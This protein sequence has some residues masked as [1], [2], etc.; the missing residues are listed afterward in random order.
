MVDRLGSRAQVALRAPSALEPNRSVH[1]F[2]SVTYVPSLICYLCSRLHKACGGPGTDKRL[3][4]L[5]GGTVSVFYTCAGNALPGG[6]SFPRD[7]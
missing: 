7:R 2:K 5:V 4:C 3:A 1:S 6:A